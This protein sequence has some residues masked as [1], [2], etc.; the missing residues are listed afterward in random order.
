[1]VRGPACRKIAREME[2]L[3]KSRQEASDSRKGKPPFYYRPG[4]SRGC[5]GHCWAGKPLPEKLQAKGY[6]EGKPIQNIPLKI[7][8]GIYL[9]KGKALLRQAKEAALRNV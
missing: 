5:A 9:R 7:Y 4:I 6:G 1:M 2:P 3:E 8:A